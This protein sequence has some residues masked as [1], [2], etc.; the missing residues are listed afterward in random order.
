MTERPRIA[1]FAGPNATIQNSAP[2]VT[3]NKARRKY[4]LPLL[5]HPDGTPARFDV[6]RPQRLAAPATVYVEQFSAHPLE[7]D[8]AELYGP[9]DGYLD[10]QGRFHKERQGPADKPVYEITLSP[11]DGVYPLPYMARQ[12]DGS[13]WEEE[14]AAPGA[15]EERARQIFYPD[16]ARIFEEVDRLGIGDKGIGNLIAARADVDFYRAFPPGGYTKGLPAAGRTDIGEGDIAPERRGRDFFPYKPYH[17]DA[18]EPRLGL[19]RI[20][21]IVQRALGSGAYAGGIWTQGS[22]RI[23]E[24]IYWLHLLLDCTVPVCG[25]AAQRPHGQVSAD[26]AKNLIDSVDY[27][28]S[29]VWADAAG[30][31][32]AGMVLIQEQQIFA[33]RDVQK[34]DARPGGYVTTGG[35]GGVIGAA[36]YDGPP[37]LTYLPQTRHS[38]LSEVNI[39]RLPVKTV[40]VLADGGRSKA[41][42]V[43]IKDSAGKLLDSAIPKVVIVKDGTYDSDDFD[44]DLEREIDLVARMEH[45]LQHAP[46]AGFV[47]EGLSPYGIMTSKARH[48]LMLRAVHLGMPVVRVGRGNNAGFSPRRDRFIGGGNLTATKARLLLMACLMKFGSLPPAADP[49]HPTEAEADAV[50]RAVSAYQAVF[51]TH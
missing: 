20:T 3:S 49:D 46:L 33:A 43:P 27:I 25:N 15:P 32:R 47:V 1:H 16:G 31:N 7:A 23:E 51:D 45:N 44:I 18:H 6:L 12:A 9:P 37:R 42:E 28:V 38:Y 8:A 29:R 35:H 2:L 26:G 4:G 39:S 19:A 40:G 22:P 21:N 24:T 14:C 34:G 13:A 11:E 41:V 17:L 50:R 36:G 5:T 48:R 10:A 30:K